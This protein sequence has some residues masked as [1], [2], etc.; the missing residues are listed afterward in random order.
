M[1]CFGD[2]LIIETFLRSAWLRLIIIYHQAI[3]IK[4]KWLKFNAEDIHCRYVTNILIKIAFGN[5]QNRFGFVVEFR[6]QMPTRIIVA[7]IQVQN[8]V[9]MDFSLVQPLHLIS[10]LSFA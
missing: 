1:F 2:F 7:F 5:L 10:N 8:G 4:R 3:N 9:N 6:A